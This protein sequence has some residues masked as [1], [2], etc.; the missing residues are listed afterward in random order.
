M[1]WL[2]IGWAWLPEPGACVF[3]LPCSSWGAGDGCAPQASQSGASRRRPVRRRLVAAQL[4]SGTKAEG[5]KKR[6]GE[7]KEERKKA[8][9]AVT[10]RLGERSGAQAAR[11]QAGLPLRLGPPGRVGEGEDGLARDTSARRLAAGEGSGQRGRV[12]SLGGTRALLVLRRSPVRVPPH[13][14]LIRAETVRPTPH[15]KLSNKAKVHKPTCRTVLLS[16]RMFPWAPSSRPRPLPEPSRDFSP[17]AVRHF[18][19]RY[20][21]VTLRFP[22]Q[23][24]WTQRELPTPEINGGA[25]QQAPRL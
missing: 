17:W 5:G 19:S 25:P 4:L 2:V 3:C 13:G 10:D 23:D 9:T 16:E 24:F 14:P 18:L 7:K 6:G 22:P 20:F 1:K 11:R 12:L 8:Q 21:A 15:D